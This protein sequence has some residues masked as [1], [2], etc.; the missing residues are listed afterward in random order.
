MYGLL[1]YRALRGEVDF[2]AGTVKAALAGVYDMDVDSHDRWEH[3]VESETTGLYTPGGIP[4]QN[5][6]LSYQANNNRVVLMGDDVH[7]LTMSAEVIRGV[8]FYLDDGDTK[9]LIAY[10]R[11]EQFRTINNAP[12]TYYLADRLIAKISV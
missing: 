7:F 3:F 9:P 6:T 12:F 8:L 2:T 11:F 4:V 1:P 10:H 5:F